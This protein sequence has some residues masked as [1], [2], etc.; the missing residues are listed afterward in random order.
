MPHA[1]RAALISERGGSRSRQPDAA[2]NFPQ[3]QH[4]TVTDDVAPIER[5]FNYMPPNLAESDRPI[6]TLCN[7]QSPVDIDF[8]HQ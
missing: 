8:K 5:R 6:G 3:Q 2:V 7:W 1:L 4:P